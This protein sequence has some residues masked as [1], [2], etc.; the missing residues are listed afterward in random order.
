MR[1]HHVC[2]PAIPFFVTIGLNTKFGTVEVLK[3][4]EHSTILQFFKTVSAIYKKRGFRVTMGHTDGEFESMREDLLDLGME[5]N[6]FSND[7]HVPEVEW[8][9]RTIKERTRCVYNTLPF[10]RISS[11]MLVE[12]V[13]ASVFW[14]NTFPSDD[15]VSDTPSPRDLIVGRKIDFNK[16]CRIQYRTYAQVHEDHDNTMDT[17]AVG[18]IALRPTGSFSASPPAVE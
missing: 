4:R 13:Q 7:E 8:Y 6:V 14:L 12:M 2:Q 3:N 1:R 9:I 17:R 5:L 16:H 11:R 15:D 10:K 18:V